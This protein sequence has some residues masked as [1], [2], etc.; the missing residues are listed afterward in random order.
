[1]VAVMVRVTLDEEIVRVVVMVEKRGVGD[2]VIFED[3]E[4]SIPIMRRS[5]MLNTAGARRCISTMMLMFKD[6]PAVRMRLRK[7]KC[8]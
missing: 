2:D 7:R 6:A 3:V 1:M 5:R 8:K 4:R